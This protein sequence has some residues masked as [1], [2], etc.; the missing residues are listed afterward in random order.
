MSKDRELTR[1]E[2]AALR[3][4]IIKNCANYD[5][6]FGCLG[7][8]SNCYMFN[9]GFTCS[10]LCTLFEE[11]LLP[12]SPEFQVLFGPSVEKRKCD[13]CGKMFP[14]SHNQ[15]YCSKKC[16]A[17]ARRKKVRDNTAAYREKKPQ[18]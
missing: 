9:V 4:V 7:L 3:R 5:Y 18:M 14:K 8:P 15:K 6:E 11:A 17:I 12:M 13:V 1:N 10:S 2:K 16:A